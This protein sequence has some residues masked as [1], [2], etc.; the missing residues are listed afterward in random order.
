[1]SPPGGQATR[2]APN[3][4]AVVQYAMRSPS[5]L[6]HRRHNLKCG[7]PSYA[8]GEPFTSAARSGAIAARA[9]GLQANVLVK[10]DYNRVLCLEPAAVPLR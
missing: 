5:E 10:R 1:V 7:K 6:G 3:A 8:G 9:S 2:F 4:Q